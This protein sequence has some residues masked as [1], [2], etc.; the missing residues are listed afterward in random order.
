MDDTKAMSQAETDKTSISRQPRHLGRGCLFA[1]VAL[2]WILLAVYFVLDL[3][4]EWNKSLTYL[5]PY[6]YSRWVT[7]HDR[8]KTAILVRD[9]FFD[10]NF[11]LFIVDSGS[12]EIPTDINE[13]IWSSRDYEPTTF[14]DWGEDIKWSGD[15]SIVAVKIENE[16]IFAYD[17]N[18]SQKIEDRE[19][20]GKLLEAHN[21]PATPPD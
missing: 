18:T 12:K 10:L 19:L 15:S 14:R 5:S 21:L 7:A 13:A 8:S 3:R 9:Y 4:A 11:R 17:F 1:F 2:T 16:Y 20:I 6:E